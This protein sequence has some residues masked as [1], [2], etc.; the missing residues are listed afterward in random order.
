MVLATRASTSVLPVA[1]PEG[2]SPI[3]RHGDRPRRQHVEFSPP[4]VLSMHAGVRIGAAGGTGTVT[5]REGPRLRGRRHRHRWRR[6]RRRTSSRGQPTPSRNDTRTPGGKH[7]RR[8][9]HKPGG[10][11]AGHTPNGWIADFRM[12]LRP[13]VLL[14]GHQ[15][16]RQPDH[17]R[18]R[19]RAVP[20]PPIR[21]ASRWPSSFSSRSTGS[22]TCLPRALE[23]S[24][25]FHARPSWP[26]GSKP[27]R[28]TESPAAAAAA[29][30]VRRTGARHQMAVFLFKSKHGS[31]YV[32]PPC[33]GDSPTWR[34]RRRLPTGSSSSP[35]RA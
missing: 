20:R 24:P 2:G 35:P 22:A 3:H 30:T 14:L 9:R 26:T 18:H 15:A 11:I 27:S 17:R 5:K 25:T 33:W 7:Q 12:S 34:A 16:R 13:P 8:H 6:C 4:L 1:V 21:C 31:T 10:G 32:P 19:R 29:T 28:P 23:C